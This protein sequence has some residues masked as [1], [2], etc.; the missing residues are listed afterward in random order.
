MEWNLVVQYGIGLFFVLLGVA[1]IAF[2]THILL[3]PKEV[4]ER[5]HALT[6][7]INKG[8][9]VN[10]DLV[11]NGLS[12]DSRSGELIVSQKLDVKAMIELYE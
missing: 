12:F 10:S 8:E 3:T 1:G 11:K 2:G 9:K 7:K 4:W 5:N 6:K